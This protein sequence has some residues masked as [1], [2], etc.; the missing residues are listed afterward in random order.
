MHDVRLFI[1]METSFTYKYHGT[2]S[3]AQPEVLEPILFVLVLSWTPLPLGLML[4]G[5]SGRWEG[6]C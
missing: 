4:R 2:S 6:G 5:G 3:F 1:F